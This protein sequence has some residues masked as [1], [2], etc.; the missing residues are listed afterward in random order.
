[1]LTIKGVAARLLFPVLG[2]LVRYRTVRL[3]ARVFKEDEHFVARCDQLK[4]S[5]QGGSPQEAVDNLSI[6]LELFFESCFRRGTIDRVLEQHGI[7]FHDTEPG[8]KR[9][10]GAIPLLQVTWRGLDAGSFAR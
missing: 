7:I 2:W 5:D 9:V 1:M 10:L 8:Y 6:T 3:E 4:I